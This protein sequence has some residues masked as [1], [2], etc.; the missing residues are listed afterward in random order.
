MGRVYLQQGR[1]AD[2]IAMLEKGRSLAG[3]VPNILAAMGQA[4]ALAGQRHRALEILAHLL[5]L[6]RTR[7]IPSTCFAVVHLGLGDSEGA[8]A[9]LERG[10]EQRDPPLTALK[11]H[12][13]YD[14]LRESPRFQALLGQ[15]GLG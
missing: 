8:L 7:Y 3:D 5:T 4:H 13:L 10:C 12:P 15:L 6:A 11:V 9:C 1:Y 2:A 14:P